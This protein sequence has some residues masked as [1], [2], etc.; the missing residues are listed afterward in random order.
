MYVLVGMAELSAVGLYVEYWFPGVPPWLSALFFFVLIN[1]VNLTNVKSFGEVEF[2]FSLVKVFAV[3]AMIFFGS[4]LLFSGKAGPHASISN[5]WSDGGFMPNGLHGMIMAMATIMFAFGGLELVGITAAEADS[6]STTIPKATNQVIYR[7][8]IFYVGALAILLCLYPWREVSQG[9]SP[10]VMIFH[11]LTS[12][13]VA[14]ALNVVILT[15]AL[16]VF[17]GSI[18]ANS[19]MLFG[20]A[21]QGNAPR[22]VAM[23]S[24]R[25]VPLAAI[26]ISAIATGSCVV[27]NYL[28]P[29]KAFEFF[30][31]LVVAALVINWALISAIHLR[32]RSFKA[33]AKETIEFPS[34][35]YPFTNYLSLVFLAGVIAVMYLSPGLRL[36]VFLIP[37][38]LFCLTIGYVV[39][40]RRT[41]PA[42]A[43][44]SL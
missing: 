34:L 42:V 44:E 26:A 7:I 35:G 28:M 39:R 6:P 17:N 13:W 23:V 30:M 36:S 3:L 19:R 29:G 4:Y 32:F 14:T 40:M 43:A 9:G 2:W 22:V 41:S 11:A 21:M 33:R 25:G 37:V 24:K 18:Y 10:F 12:H 38:W 5:L 27:L 1:A 31:G 20:L 8:L 15:A 16:S